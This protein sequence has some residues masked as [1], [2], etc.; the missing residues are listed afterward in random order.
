[1]GVRLAV[2]TTGFI[3]FDL[4]P[5]RPLTDEEKAHRKPYAGPREV[6]EG[7]VVVD[8]DYDTGLWYSTDCS[9]GHIVS[10]DVWAEYEAKRAELDELAGVMN[11]GPYIP[12]WAQQGRPEPEPSDF[13]LAIIPPYTPF[14]DRI[15]RVKP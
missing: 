7:C 3:P 14:R 9:G 2:M 11:A 4:F 10:A 6:P 1:M 8:Q 5:T 12:G 15:A 13:T